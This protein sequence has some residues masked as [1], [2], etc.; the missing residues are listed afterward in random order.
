MNNYKNRIGKTKNHNFIDF[1]D[2]ESLY[3]KRPLIDS[4]INCYIEIFNESDVW[5]EDY[6]YEDVIIILQKQLTGAASI[7]LCVDSRTSEVI[8]FCWAQLI[9]ASEVHDT[10]NAV[11]YVQ[12]H[13]S[14]NI[15]HQ[16]GKLVGKESVIY[17]QDLGVSKA[18]RGKIHL[19][20]LIASVLEDVAVQA[21]TRKIF[22]WSIKETCVKKLA[23]RVNINPAFTADNMQFFA[24]HLPNLKRYVS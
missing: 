12:S 24:G 18:Y 20:Q 4:L 11:Q 15:K 6:T 17:L 16:L 23:Q 1:Q 8:G 14:I 22:F 9:T 5:S 7:R 13:S 10:I 19:G 21:N 2:F 3:K